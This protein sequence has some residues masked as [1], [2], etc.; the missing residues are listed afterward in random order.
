MVRVLMRDLCACKALIEA[1]ASVDRSTME[2]HEVTVK[3]DDCIGMLQPYCKEVDFCFVN[4]EMRDSIEETALRLRTD[5]RAYF[6]A[7]ADILFKDRLVPRKFKPF[8][9][10]SRL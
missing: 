1:I 8:Y 10:G 7:R 5:T 3:F 6:T 4:E 9:T 2:Y